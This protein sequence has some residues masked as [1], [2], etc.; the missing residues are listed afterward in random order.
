[1]TQSNVILE[2]FLTICVLHGFI[3]NSRNSRALRPTLQASSSIGEG[4][5]KHTMYMSVKAREVPGN[6]PGE[7]EVQNDR[8]NDCILLSIAL[9]LASVCPQGYGG[10][11][12]K[13]HDVGARKPKTARVRNEPKEGRER[14]TQLHQ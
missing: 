6:A 5:V 12:V 11:E 13:T 3:A 9:I 8:V 4:R 7:P 10:T 1:M 14:V 2:I